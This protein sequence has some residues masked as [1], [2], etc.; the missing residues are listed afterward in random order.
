MNGYE[1]E[2]ALIQL[3]T[4]HSYDKLFLE[5]EKPKDARNVY[6]VYAAKNETEGVQIALRAASDVSGLRLRLT[7]PPS[8]VTAQM[9]LMYGATKLHD[10][11]YTDPAVPL[12]SDEAIELKAKETLPLL[13]EFSVASDAPVGESEFCLEVLDGAGSVLTEAKI[14]LH[15]WDFAMPIA[16][17]FKTTVHTM[18]A[19]RAAHYELL[20]DHNFCARMLPVDIRS[21]EADAYMSDPRVTCFFQLGVG[22]DGVLKEIY[23]KLEGHLE[24]LEKACFYA[25]DEPRSLEMAQKLAEYCERLR[26][27]CPEFRITAPFYTNVQI[28]ENTD[29]IDFMAKMIDIHCPKLACWDD[30]N[31]YSK[32][33]AEKY[34]PF[35]ERMKEHQK[36]GDE[37]WTYVC[38][39]PLAPY[40]SVR[41][42]DEGLGSRVLFW[43]M[44][45][46]EIDGFLYWNATY[47]DRLPEKDPWKCLDTFGDGIYG[48]GILIYPGAPVG[49]DG[50]IAS[51]RLKI[52]R[53]GVDDIEL[54]YL[55]ERL[56]GRDWV[57]ERVNKVTSSLT[58]VDVTSD[59]FYALRAEIGN[60]VEE[61]MKK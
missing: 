6:T 54:F 42:D 61:K 43:Q 36:R 21:D 56:F 14:T 23:A 38:N 49:V 35:A 19:P 59:E 28:D 3:W 5:S 45:Q 15:V 26:A 16:K 50:P 31:I 9:F 32:E 1:K 13:M 53:D 34:P 18:A 10:V 24:W 7:E 30:E 48:D 27:L 52:M 51:I 41:L 4:A 57:M 33:Q 37:V 44:Y 25:L 55:A 46:R 40:P 12:F 11:T 20:L 2:Q 17:S 29:Q 58:S 8:G 60:A 22:D 47:Y 39:N